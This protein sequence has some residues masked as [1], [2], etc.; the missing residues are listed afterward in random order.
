M[1]FKKWCPSLGAYIGRLVLAPQEN[2]A[3]NQVNSD[4]F[5]LCSFQSFKFMQFCDTFFALKKLSAQHLPLTSSLEAA[6]F[7]MCLWKK[8]FAIPLKTAVLASR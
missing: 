1:T 3:M 4:R 8:R 6:V 7:C 2:F 5:S